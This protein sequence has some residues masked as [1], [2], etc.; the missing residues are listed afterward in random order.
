MFTSRLERPV[1]AEDPQRPEAHPEDGEDRHGRE[2]VPAEG[3]HDVHLVTVEQEPVEREHGH[4]RAEGAQEDDPASRPGVLA[5]GRLGEVLALPEVALDGQAD[6]RDRSHPDRQGLPEVQLPGDEQQGS[7]DLAGRA[8]GQLAC[9]QERLEGRHPDGHEPQR[10][11]GVLLQPD[12]RHQHRGEHDP[13]EQV[14]RQVDLVQPAAP[15]Q[16]RVEVP[17]HVGQVTAL[18]LHA[19]LVPRVGVHHRTDPGTSLGADRGLVAQTLE[20]PGEVG[21]LDG[22]QGV[23]RGTA[24]GPFGCLAQRLTAEQRGLTTQDVRTTTA[25]LLLDAGDAELVKLVVDDPLLAPLG[26][27][28]VLEAV[29]SH[30][31]GRLGGQDQVRLEVLNHL[32][33]TL[34]VRVDSEDEVELVVAGVLVP[35]P[36]Q[37]THLALDTMVVLVDV[38]DGEVAEERRVAASDLGRPVGAVVDHDDDAVDRARLLEQRLDGGRDV[39]LLVV[40]GD[41]RQDGRQ[42]R[43]LLH[44]T[45][46]VAYRFDATPDAS[47]EVDDARG[48]AVGLV[49]SQRGRGHRVVGFTYHHRHRSSAALAYGGELVSDRSAMCFTDQRAGLQTDLPPLT[50]GRSNRGCRHTVTP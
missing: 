36:V 31:A 41:D 11:E 24:V 47:L 7:E 39:V 34:D 50:G 17:H 16:P 43:C 22:R 33:V 38:L 37:R 29:A 13:D 12:A 46:A 18:P 32:G 25:K 19:L 44:L 28:L 23:P 35:C 8:V 9:D 3:Q 30:H 45:A 40:R 1:A 48:V 20:R 14:E 27:F 15:V 4:D 2:R 10:V 5:L 26:T 6:L 49:V 21:V 42:R